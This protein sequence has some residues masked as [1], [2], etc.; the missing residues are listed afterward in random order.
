MVEE[1]IPVEL[2]GFYAAHTAAETK[3]ELVAALEEAWVLLC[4]V[5]DNRVEQAKGHQLMYD[6]LRAKNLL[7]DL[8]R[9][10]VQRDAALAALAKSKD[11]LRAL[12][13]ELYV[14]RMMMED[15]GQEFPPDACQG[16]HYVC[17]LET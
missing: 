16:C 2:R 15:R 1:K 5:E 10:K 8:D 11:T 9:V 3:E 13:D 12:S 6:N 7:V 14:R 4:R 17:I